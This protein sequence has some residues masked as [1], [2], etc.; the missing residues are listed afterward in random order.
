MKLRILR[1]PE[2]DRVVEPDPMGCTL[3]RGKDNDLVLLDE[4]VSRHHCRIVKAAAGWTVEDL[5]SVNGIRVNGRRVEG[6][7][8]LSEGDILAMCEQELRVEFEEQPPAV[9]TLPRP[10][11]SLPFPPAMPPSA[12]P[13]VPP[14]SPVPPIA[15]EVSEASAG[16]VLR[17]LPLGRIAL[18]AAMC[19]LIGVLAYLLLS[20]P[21]PAQPPPAGSAPVAVVAEPG[22]PTVAASPLSDQ[23]LDDLLKEEAAIAANGGSPAPAVPVAPPG[24]DVAAVEGAA[25]PSAPAVVPA[26]PAPGDPAASEMVLVRSVPEGATVLIDDEEKGVTPLLVAGLSKGRHRVTLQLPGYQDHQRQIHVPDVIASAPYVLRQRP[27]TLYVVSDPPGVSIWHGSQWLGTAPILLQDLP[28]GET[29]L[30]LA[31]AGCPPRREKVTISGVRGEQLS[32][33]MKPD[34]GNLDVET[35][36]PGCQVVI[37]GQAMGATVGDP[38][39]P[40]SPGVLSVPNLLVGERSLRIEHPCGAAS[41]RK[42]IVAL[43]E[44]SKQSVRLWVPDTQ[45]TLVD[46]T[47]KSGMLMERNE[48]GDI[49][50]AQS[51]LPKDMVRYLKPRVR[52]ERPLGDAE[53][54]EV[55]QQVMAPDGVPKDEAEGAK[56]PDV[57]AAGLGDEG[58][59]TKPA[60]PGEEAKPAAKDR[61]IEIAADE[62]DAKLA[63]I[64]KT[65]FLQRYNDATLAI[66]GKPS[67]VRR[68]GLVGVV[69]FGRRVRCEFDREV[70][71]VERDKIGAVTD[72]ATT[73]LTVRGRVQGF[74][75]DRLVL[76]EC[77]P[78]FGA[79]E[80]AP[81]K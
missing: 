33:A 59:P 80:V 18:L 20:G 14:V 72:T 15:D 21:G 57:A 52:A 4:G 23:E 41:V 74:V 17:A 71:D 19:L 24:E 10:P 78:I 25:P 43:G 62:L 3:G 65:T 79:P 76:R 9:S 81:K 26:A 8:I 34:L 27:N 22:E 40:G 6:S 1:G 66:T 5:G 46:G 35:V 61:V 51:P 11:A 36:P 16:S 37:D 56:G 49:V 70:F 7:Q 54:R 45:V 58:A 50:L 60:A 55:F 75:G 53:A 64:P 13:P 2:A 67:S 68:D 31:M 29:T 44:T 42:L 38:N 69:M 63:A 30:T 39:G 73:P 47:T 28:A 48:Q 32:V 77:R 12:V